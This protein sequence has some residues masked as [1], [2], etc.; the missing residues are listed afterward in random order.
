[1]EDE[2]INKC[3]YFH[4]CKIHKPNTNDGCNLYNSYEDILHLSQFNIY[5]LDIYLQMV[6]P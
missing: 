3:R 2:H 1:M 5:I 6:H 4:W